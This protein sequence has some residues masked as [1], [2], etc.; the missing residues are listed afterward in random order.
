VYFKIHWSGLLDNSCNWRKH[1]VLHSLY[2]VFVKHA[3]ELTRKL[4]FFFS[5]MTTSTPEKQDGLKA[6]NQAINKIEE[7]ITSMGGVFT[8]QM[9]VSRVAIR[10]AHSFP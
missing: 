3:A 5:V 6:L 8:I 1:P 4:S 2:V 10:P 9:A 7:V